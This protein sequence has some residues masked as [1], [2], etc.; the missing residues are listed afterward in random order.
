[1]ENRCLDGSSQ[2]SPISMLT[3][4]LGRG[5]GMFGTARAQRKVPRSFDPSTDTIR[6]GALT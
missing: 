6:P 3:G 4:L 2:R 5:K 1:M